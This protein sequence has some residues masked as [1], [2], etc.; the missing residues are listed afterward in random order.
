MSQKILPQKIVQLTDNKA[1]EAAAE[2]ASDGSVNTAAADGNGDAAAAPKKP[3]RRRKKPANAA[4][5]DEAK[6]K[7]QSEALPKL[8]TAS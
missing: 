3:A 6:P 1:P 5:A 4:K 8:K 7:M 2:P